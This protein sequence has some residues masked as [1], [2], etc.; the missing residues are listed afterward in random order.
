MHSRERGVALAVVV[1]FIAGMS[2]LV[3]GIVMTARTDV[4]L[5]QI[6]MARAQVSAAG[7]GAINLL[8]ADVIEGQTG[9]NRNRSGA[10]QDRFRLGED[11]VS[12]VAVTEDLLVNINAASVDELT[13]AFTA[14]GAIPAD[15]AGALAGAVVQYRRARERRVA[16]FNAIE[17]LLDVDGVN[18]AVVDGVRDFIVAS[19][20]GRGTFIGSSNESGSSSGLRPQLQ[21]LRGLTPETRSRDP[22]LRAQIGAAVAEA[23][24]GG[25]LRVDAMV[26]R[27]SDVW[28]RRRWASPGSGSGALPWRFVRTE[29]VRMV[30]R[31]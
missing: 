16:R 18:R 30:A 24:G 19:Q 27:G 25:L 20:S 11:L 29:P 5:A 21:Q 13:A 3:A 4:R 26:R 22:E 9:G 6:Q 15:A 23:P 1:W 31:R 17:D 7:D 12:V 14:S 8:L 2:L 10:F 28:L